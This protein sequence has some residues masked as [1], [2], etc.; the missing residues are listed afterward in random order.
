ME[1][2]R[3]GT[4]PSVPDPWAAGWLCTCAASP[5]QGRCQRRARHAVP[6]PRRCPEGR[7]GEHVALAEVH[8]PVCLHGPRC[9]FLFFL[10]CLMMRAISPR[11]GDSVGH[12]YTGL[13]GTTRSL[14]TCSISP[15]HQLQCQ[16]QTEAVRGASLP[17]PP[18]QA[19]R[20]HLGAGGSARSQGSKGPRECSA[21]AH[22]HFPIPLGCSTCSSAESE[23]SS[24][25]PLSLAPPRCAHHA[26]WHLTALP[27][28]SQ[29]QL[30][31]SLQFPSSVTRG[32]YSYPCSHSFRAFLH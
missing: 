12:S 11:C 3:R 6:S 32:S 17:S 7:R 31:L 26:P 23:G 14:S 16:L 29:P 10:T 25:Q 24:S 21:C 27:P 30:V 13:L 20:G 9:S 18:H 5:L 22:A 1:W 19:H 4:G 15:V 28:L 2:S 8:S